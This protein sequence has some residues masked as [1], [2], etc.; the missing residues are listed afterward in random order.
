MDI[1]NSAVYS[2]FIRANAVYNLYIKGFT[3]SD[4]WVA[5]IRIPSA[6]LHTMKELFNLTY[7]LK[8]SQIRFVISKFSAIIKP[9]VS[10]IVPYMIFLNA[11]KQLS[12]ETTV[13]AQHVGFILS[14]KER[15]RN[16]ILLNARNIVLTLAPEL[17]H[18][19]ILLD[20]DPDTLSSMDATSLGALDKSVT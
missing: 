16:T 14:G 20:Y 5:I 19:F 15:I 6:I 12:K 8:V 1:I 7:I 18:Y 3:V 2:I 4:T 17:A 13:I 11:W 9:T 10:L